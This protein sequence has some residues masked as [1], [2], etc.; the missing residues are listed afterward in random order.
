MDPNKSKY[1]EVLNIMNY[2][3]N[4]KHLRKH[5]ME[6]VVWLKYLDTE[7]GLYLWTVMWTSGESN[8]LTI[9]GKIKC[10]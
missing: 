7:M 4:I 3:T 5:K 1:S 8:S 6:I 9:G 10:R 2:T